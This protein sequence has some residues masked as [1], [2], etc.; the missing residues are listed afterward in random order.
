MLGRSIMKAIYFQEVDGLVRES[1]RDVYI[2]FTDLEKV[3]DR[4][5]EGTWNALEKKYVS[6]HCIGH[7]KDMYSRSITSLRTI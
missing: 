3:Y 1:R 6:E 7:S 2:V 5:M 4:I